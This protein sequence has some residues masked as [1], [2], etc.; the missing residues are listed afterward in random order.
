MAKSSGTTRSSSSSNPKGISKSGGRNLSQDDLIQ[1]FKNEVELYDENLYSD[2]DRKTFEKIIES[3]SYKGELYRAVTFE[4]AKEAEQF[5]MNLEFKGELNQ[6]N[7]YTPLPSK[8]IIE[9]QKAAGI[10][11]AKE[12]NVISFS[13]RL[14]PQYLINEYAYEKGLSQHAVVFHTNG[15]KVVGKDLSSEGEVAISTKKNHFYVESV[16]RVKDSRLP[17]GYYYRIELA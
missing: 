17:A 15:K 6:L 9:R 1:A 11:F 16:Q 8:N 13:K 3:S 10:K 4:S 12:R 14:N 7:D 5:V 2:A